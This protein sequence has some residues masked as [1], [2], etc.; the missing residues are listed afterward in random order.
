[1][2]FPQL[3]VLD[4]TYNR[5]QSSWPV[6]DNTTLGVLILY[7]NDLCADSGAFWSSTAPLV[8]DCL[9]NLCC[10]LCS[11]AKCVFHFQVLRKATA[12]C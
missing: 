8:A 10:L 1:M 7:N 4:L 12:M 11:R 9:M 6:F 3:Q 2:A 5:L